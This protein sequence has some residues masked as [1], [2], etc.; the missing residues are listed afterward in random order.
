[1]TGDLMEKCSDIS[2]KNLHPAVKDSDF[3]IASDVNNP[4]FGKMVLSMFMLLKKAL[5]K[6]IYQF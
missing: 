4:L 5:L 3:T 2:T 1:M 6:M